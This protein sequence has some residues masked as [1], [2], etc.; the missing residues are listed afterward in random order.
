MNKYQIVAGRLS[1]PLIDAVQ[2]AEHADDI[3]VDDLGTGVFLPV[4]VWEEW[5]KPD[6]ITVTIESGDTANG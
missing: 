6:T 3:T 5:G 1:E 2:F 4:K